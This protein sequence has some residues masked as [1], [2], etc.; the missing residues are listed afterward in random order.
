ML[1][2]DV[3]LIIGCFVIYYSLSLLSFRFDSIIAESLN[4]FDFS[5]SAILGSC[6]LS[7]ISDFE[8]IPILFLSN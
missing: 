6:L 7:L 2:L 8:N 3:D 5:I 4:Q 1:L